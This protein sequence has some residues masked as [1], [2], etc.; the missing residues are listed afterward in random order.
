MHAV[1]APQLDSLAERA[2]H[3][4]RPEGPAQSTGKCEGP[5]ESQGRKGGDEDH[6]TI[7]GCLSWGAKRGSVGGS[8]RI[9]LRHDALH[10]LPE[11]SCR[12]T[13]ALVDYLLQLVMRNGRHEVRRGHC[14]ILIG[15]V[16]GHRPD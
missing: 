8:F 10:G 7:A 6:W 13:A 1:V 14:A 16:D 5:N 15:E 3:A 2:A 4:R 9:K 12:P 11:P